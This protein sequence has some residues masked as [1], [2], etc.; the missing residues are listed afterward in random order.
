MLMHTHKV[1]S[2][3]LLFS[4]TKSFEKFINEMSFILLMGLILKGLMS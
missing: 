1:C 3:R 2:Y 4:K